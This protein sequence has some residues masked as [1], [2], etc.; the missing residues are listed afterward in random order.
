VPFNGAGMFVRLRNWVEDATAGIKIRAD[1]H[2]IED[3]NF[4]TGISQCIARDGQ[5]TVL[6]N[7]PMNSKR[8]TALS[9][10]VDPQDAATKAYADTKLPLAGGTIIGD[11]GVTGTILASGYRTRLGVPGPF[12]GSYFNFNWTGDLEAWVDSTNLGALATQA[13]A[14]NAANTYANNAAAPKVNR[15]GDTITGGL[16]V[17][18]ELIASANY[19]R[20]QYSGS[21]GYIQWNGGANYGLGGG[22]TIWHTGNLNPIQNGRLVSAGDLDV[23][24]SGQ[25][26]EPYNGA[27]ITGL[28]KSPANGNPMTG[29][30]W[31]YLQLLTPGGW[32]TVAYA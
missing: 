19:L 6:Q 27:V 1:Y 21:P 31:R 10:P 17:N 30:R 22:G 15:A 32:Y 9:D 26:T 24:A 14:N 12:G 25:I 16:T 11:L 5:S 8:L 18:G 23:P 2:D 7:I 3:D 28:V 20:F 13:F 4:A 29:A